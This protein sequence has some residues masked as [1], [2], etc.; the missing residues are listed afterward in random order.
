MGK[1]EKAKYLENTLLKKQQKSIPLSS[2]PK[3]GVGEGRRW[4]GAIYA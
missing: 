1:L 4:G 3:K 2:K